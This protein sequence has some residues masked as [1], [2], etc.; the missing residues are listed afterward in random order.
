MKTIIYVEVLT[1]IVICRTLKNISLSKAILDHLK[2]CNVPEEDIDKEFNKFKWT[3][4]NTMTLEHYD[5]SHTFYEV[6]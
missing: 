4:K 5:G 1:G 2:E 6:E 3:G